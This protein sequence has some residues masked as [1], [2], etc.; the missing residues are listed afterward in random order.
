MEGV[1]RQ[2]P[3]SAAIVLDNR[4]CPSTLAVVSVSV[5]GVACLYGAMQS[6]RGLVSHAGCARVLA[7]CGATIREAGGDTPRTRNAHTHRA[8]NET[9]YFSSFSTH[10]G[11]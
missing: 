4:P 11:S 5:H 6:Q 10:G 2:S 3:F 9:T 7:H 1:D 8:G